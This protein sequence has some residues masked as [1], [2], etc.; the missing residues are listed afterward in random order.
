M[1]YGRFSARGFN[2][3]SLNPQILKPHTFDRDIPRLPQLNTKPGTLILKS[4]PKPETLN[5]LN[6]TSRHPWTAQLS[7]NLHLDSPGFRV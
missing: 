5:L 1:F 3:A 6:H 4:H 7:L 2:K